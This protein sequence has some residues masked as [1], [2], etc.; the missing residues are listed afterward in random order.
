ML[1]MKF[2]IV[3]MDYI[4]LWVYEYIRSCFPDR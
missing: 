1:I 4:H 2:Q 3:R